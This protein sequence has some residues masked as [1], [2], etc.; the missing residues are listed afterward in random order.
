MGNFEI[1]ELFFNTFTFLK[2]K[3]TRI[4]KRTQCNS[5]RFVD[6]HWHIC[7]LHQRT[8]QNWQETQL[9]ICKGNCKPTGGVCTE[10]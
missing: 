3:I 5:V 6:T 8:K 2:S 7:R 9:A 4:K 10:S 1:C